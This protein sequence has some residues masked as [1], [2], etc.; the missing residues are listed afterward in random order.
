MPICN[1]CSCEKKQEAFAKRDQGAY[2]KTCK[3][4]VNMRRKQWA[5]DNTEKIKTYREKNYEKNPDGFAART[6]RWLD[7]NPGRKRTYGT[8]RRKG[9]R[10]ATLPWV[11]KQE[12]DIIYANCPKGHHVDH[13]VPLQHELV[14]GLHVPWNLQY[15]TA[16]ENLQKGNRF[17]G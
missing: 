15:L 12:L 8:L 9:Q 3:S 5:L 1:K 6:Q 14:C 10:Y 7:K 13:I 17:N 16:K 11:D 4:C 2:S